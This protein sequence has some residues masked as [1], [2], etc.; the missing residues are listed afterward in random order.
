MA[1]R[2]VDFNVD[3]GG[4]RSILHVDREE[5]YLPF[6]ERDA[7]F[8]EVVGGEFNADLVAR[9]DANKVLP[10]PAGHMG[11]DFVSPFDLHFEARIGQGLCY[12]PLDLE[13]FFLRFRH[14]GLS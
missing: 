7:A 14:T 13:R 6:A 10:H 8:G 4:G 1:H 5:Y 3:L 9:D 11:H 12:S 2:N